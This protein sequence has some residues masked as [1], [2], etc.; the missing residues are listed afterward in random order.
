MRHPSITGFGVA[1]LTLFVTLA[2]AGTAGAATA[3]PLGTADGFAVLGGTTV[4]STGPTVLNGDLGVSPGSACTGFPAPCTG[5]GPGMVNGT[6][7]AADTPAAQAQLDLTTAFNNAAGQ[8]CNADLSTMIL[9]TGVPSL[10]P[11]VY[12]FSSSAQLTGTLTLDGQGNP[13]AVFIFKIGT[14][15]TTAP[16]SRVNLINGAQACNVFWKLDTAVLDTTTSFAGNIL[17]LTSIS[18]NTGATVDGRLLA[19][20][21][22]VSLQ[23]NT[24]TRAVCAAVTPTRPTVTITGLPTKCIARNFKLHVTVAD[25][26]VAATTD[27]F[28]DGTRVKHSTKSS[29]TATIKAKGLKPGTH[30][31]R[32]VT[33]NAAGK[34]RV[35]KS[36][37]QRCGTAVIHFTG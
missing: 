6:I 21:G 9:G 4:T 28:L 15:L 5:G 32:V 18:A 17:A 12:C 20:N 1:L 24:V 35:S 36:R 16:G 26:G 8:A 25:P 13:N 37:F 7:H 33:T 2:L 23:S 14:Q 30:K 34:T 10:T 19:R 31:I 3:V 22:Q 29:F 11:G 27:V